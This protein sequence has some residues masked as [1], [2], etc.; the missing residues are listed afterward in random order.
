[1]ILLLVQVFLNFSDLLVNLTQLLPFSSQLLFFLQNCLNIFLVFYFLHFIFLSGAEIGRFIVMLR[2]PSSVLKACA[3]FALLQVDDIGDSISL[4]IT[5]NIKI[6]VFIFS[7]NYVQHD[8]TSLTSLNSFVGCNFL[9]VHH[10]RWS[11][12]PPPCGPFAEYWCT[13][14]STSC[15][16][17]SICS[18]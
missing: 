6:Q 16:C 1:M 15:S 18:N 11:A 10:S 8:Q 9:V 13:T 14:G 17:G 5:H 3:A 2:N 12:C 7:Q 4:S